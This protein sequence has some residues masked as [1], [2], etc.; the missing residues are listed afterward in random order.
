MWSSSILSLLKNLLKKWVLN[1]HAYGSLVN[2]LTR[3]LQMD[4]APYPYF[5]IHLRM[6]TSNNKHFYKTWLFSLP[7]LVYHFRL[8]RMFSYNIWHYNCVH[9]WFSLPRGPTQK[10]PYL[11]LVEKTKNLYTLATL[12]IV[13]RQW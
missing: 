12:K 2:L 9:M 6:I 8:L 3:S 11:E 7:R 10:K 5:G 4:V 1:K 13:C